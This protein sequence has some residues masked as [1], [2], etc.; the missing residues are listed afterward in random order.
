MPPNS[1]KSISC[2]SS[3]SQDFLNCWYHT[4]ITKVYLFVSINID[5]TATSHEHQ[6]YKNKNSLVNLVFHFFQGTYIMDFYIWI[7][8]LPHACIRLCKINST[9]AALLNCQKSMYCIPYLSI[10]EANHIC[11]LTSHGVSAGGSKEVRNLTL[12]RMT[13]T[14][15]HQNKRGIQM[16]YKYYTRQ[17]KSIVYTTCNF[18]SS[19]NFEKK[20]ICKRQRRRD[21]IPHCSYLR[22]SLIFRKK[23]KNTVD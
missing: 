16:L 17:N 18:D 15:K 23:K 7:Q 20:N 3:S 19:S 13:N 12:K 14:N 8:H 6:K 1:R 22:I 11:E 21:A 5:K 10:Y 9:Q 4:C 2:T